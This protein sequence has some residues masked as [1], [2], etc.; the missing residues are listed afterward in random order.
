LISDWPCDL[1]DMAMKFGLAVALSGLVG[2]ERERRARAAG[3]RTHILVCLGS[4]LLMAVGSHIAQLHAAS[5]QMQWLDTGRIAAGIITGIGFLGAGTIITVA[6]EHRGLTTA[7]TI[8]F[9]AALGVAVGSNM[10]ITATIATG[11][12]LAVVVLLRPLTGRLPTAERCK[13][14]IAL[15]RDTARF[16]DVQA[17]LRDEGFHILGTHVRVTSADS[18]LF[19]QFELGTAGRRPLHHLVEALQRRFPDIVRI[20]LEY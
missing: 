19:A 10:Y 16:E 15:P 12:A 20:A 4:T 17:A 1:A 7:A 2:L 8:W 18:Q 11:V 6:G 3:L 13:L 5:G 14:T 9:V